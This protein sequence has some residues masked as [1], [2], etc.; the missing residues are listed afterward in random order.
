MPRSARGSAR[1]GLF[2]ILKTWRKE[3]RGT[4]SGPF[5][6]VHVQYMVVAVTGDAPEQ[7]AERIAL[8]VDLAMMHDAYIDTLFSSIVVLAYGIFPKRQQPGHDIAGLTVALHEA[9]GPHVKAI[10]GETDGHFGLIGG[11]NRVAYSFIVP[12][13]TSVF[14]KLAAIPFGEFISEPRA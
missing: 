6:P 13:F 7:V 8:V 2:S 9:L 14:G 10:Y 11:Q 3:N 12:D 5:R 4:T 1:R